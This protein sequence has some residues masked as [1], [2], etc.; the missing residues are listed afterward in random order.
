MSED[1]L[2]ASLGFHW[3]DSI[4]HHF[5]TLYQDTITFNLTPADAVLDNG[6]FATMHKQIVI[7][8]QSLVLRLSVMLCTST[9]SLA[10]RFLLEMCTMAC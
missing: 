3:V 6:D 10:L 5:L 9:L 7:L 8:F 1:S 2:R 4:R